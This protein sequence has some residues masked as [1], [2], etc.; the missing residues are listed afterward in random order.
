MVDPALLLIAAAGFSVMWWRHVRAGP[1]DA[2]AVIEEAL[3]IA[4]HV[5]RHEAEARGQSVEPLHL[6][7]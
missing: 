4:V 6:L 7:Y 5:A 1:R 3:D 2:L